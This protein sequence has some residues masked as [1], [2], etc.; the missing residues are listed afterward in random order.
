MNVSD[1][2]R[3]YIVMGL[4]VFVILGLISAS[5]MGSK[6]DK[7]FQANNALYGL[8][9]QQLQEGNYSDAL[10]TSVVLGESQKASEVVN[11]YTALTAINVGETEK[12]LLHMQRALD[13]N[14]HKVEDSM[15]MLQY[16]EMLV[17]AEKKDEATQVLERC[18]VLPV[19]EIYPDYQERILQLQEQVATQM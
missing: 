12:A 18:E 3:R 2:A 9:T 8:M 14:P 4:S 1:S 16:A 11:Y 13:I 6:Q 5:I 7:E 10:A 17:Q 19:P 15:F